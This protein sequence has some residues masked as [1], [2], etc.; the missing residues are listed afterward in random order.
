VILLPLRQ[1]RAG[2]PYQGHQ[3]MGDQNE[4][5]PHESEL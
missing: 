5:F 4:H 2:K 1:D 3:Q